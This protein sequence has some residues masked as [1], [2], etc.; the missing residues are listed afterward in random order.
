MNK[1]ELRRRTDISTTDTGTLSPEQEKCHH[2]PSSATEHD[3]KEQGVRQ[4]LGT[5]FTSSW[6]SPY[7][8]TIWDNYFTTLGMVPR[9]QWV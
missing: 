5:V 8:A 1:A 9:L 2:F 6:S 4:G 3:G 7:L